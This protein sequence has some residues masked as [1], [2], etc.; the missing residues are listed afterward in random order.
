MQQLWHSKLPE[1]AKDVKVLKEVKRRLGG[2]QAIE[3]LAKRAK[4][5]VQGI[6]PS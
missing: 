6:L 2:P 5:I 3:G 4:R 1:D